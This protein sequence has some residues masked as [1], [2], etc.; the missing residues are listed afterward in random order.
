VAHSRRLGVVA[1]LAPLTPERPKNVIL[2]SPWAG[3]RADYFLRIKSLAAPAA[4]RSDFAK[5]CGYRL[6]VSWLSGRHQAFFRRK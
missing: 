4:A 1:L 5:A 6:P 2:L 3:R